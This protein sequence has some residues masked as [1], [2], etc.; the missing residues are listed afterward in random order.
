MS[1]RLDSIGMNIG[2]L[3]DGFPRSLKQ[4]HL[5][6]SYLQKQSMPLSFVLNFEAST[7]EL[8]GRLGGRMVHLRSGRTYHPEANPPKVDGQ[9]DVTGEPLTVR[10]DD[11]PETIRNR[12]RVYHDSTMP[13]LEHYDAHDLLVNVS[14]DGGLPHSVWAQVQSI[15][16]K[17]ME[18]SLATRM[19]WTIPLQPSSEQQHALLHYRQEFV[20]QIVSQHWDGRYQ[21]D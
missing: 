1:K 12:L 15:L 11:R 13:I 2:W 3:V 16:N 20:K 14:V 9:D 18:I 17:A 6:D 7:E 10:D 19:D 5:F 21:S 8:V 4:A